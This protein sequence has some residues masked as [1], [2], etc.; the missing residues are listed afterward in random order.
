MTTSHSA[1]ASSRALVGWSDLESGEVGPQFSVVLQE[2]RD[3][4]LAAA[5]DVPL[6]APVDPPLSRRH[7]PSSSVAW[8]CESHQGSR[9]IAF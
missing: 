3:Q 7:A 9:V 5:K 4:I 2:H 1:K 6:P 8:C